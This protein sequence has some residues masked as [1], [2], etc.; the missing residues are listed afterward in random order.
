MRPVAAPLR[1]E[2]LL[3]PHNS[4]IPE[5]LTPKRNTKMRAAFYRCRVT[6][7]QLMKPLLA[8]AVLSLTA[9][10][11]VPAIAQMSEPKTQAEC[12]KNKN[13]RWDQQ[14]NKCLKK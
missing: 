3:Q 13:M 9:A 2:P 6:M 1:R 14:S 10:L 11:T 4:E 8:V 5:P 7:E 12:E